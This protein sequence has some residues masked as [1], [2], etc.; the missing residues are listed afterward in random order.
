MFI[1]QADALQ[2]LVAQVAR[3]PQVALDCEADSYHHYEEKLCLLQLTF[4]VDGQPENRVVDP[5]AR[6]LD[7][8]P[9][10]AALGQRRLLVHAADNDLRL[11]GKHGASFAASE[12]F[13]TMIAAQYLG[14]PGLGLAA[15]LQRHLGVTLDKALQVAD[16]SRRPLTAAMIEYAALDTQH[17]PALAARMEELLAQAGRLAWHQ[18]ACARLVAQRPT[19]KAPRIDDPERWRISGSSDL[20]GRERAVLRLLWRWREAEARAR[21]SAPFRVLGNDVLLRMARV[22]LAEGAQA[23]QALA[24]SRRHD[25]QL[26]AALAAGLAVPERELP[27]RRAQ[28]PEERPTARQAARLNR[29]IAA[30]D[31][32]AGA[33]A[34]TPGVL[35]SR[36]ALARLWDEDAPTQERLVTTAGLLPWQAERL[37]ATLGR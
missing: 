31:Q 29:L 35:A 5:L 28:E 37:A 19:P 3:A 30:R 6:G 23:A 22:A 36:A 10:L 21:D 24:P 14:E 18:Q 8:Q 1:S 16:W 13:D 27:P 12:V 33:L 2:A 9:L 4:T 17:L 26:Q 7:L 34:L 15:L 25:A 32:A 11:I 20:S